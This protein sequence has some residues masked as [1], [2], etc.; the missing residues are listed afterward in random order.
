MCAINAIAHFLQEELRLAGQLTQLRE[1]R[2]AVQVNSLVVRAAALPA[3]KV[4]ISQM[5]AAL[6]FDRAGHDT[7]TI[8][9]ATRAS[10]RVVVNYYV[11]SS[12]GIAGVVSRTFGGP[13]L[14]HARR[15]S[16]PGRFASP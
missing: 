7:I 1:V 2:P 11:A 12:P 3:Q 16:I 14:F 9:H 6:G 5:M 8:C 4:E 15:C 10:I 13:G